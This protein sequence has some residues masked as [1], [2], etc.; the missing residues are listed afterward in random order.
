MAGPHLYRC[1]CSATTCSCCQTT[2]LAGYNTCV[3]EVFGRGCVS[4]HLETNLDDVLYGLG[5]IYAP[6]QWT[7]HTKTYMEVFT[8]EMCIA[9]SHILAKGD[10]R[11]IL[12]HVVSRPEYC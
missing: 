12:T 2:A 9:Q 11:K 10:K 4:R 6:V 3:L 5:S 7:F 1:H 8:V